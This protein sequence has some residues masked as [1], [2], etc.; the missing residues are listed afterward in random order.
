M[1]E[2]IVFQSILLLKPKI[3]FTHN[4]IEMNT[5][6]RTVSTISYFAVQLGHAIYVRKGAKYNTVG[7][8]FPITHPINRYIKG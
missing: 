3:P 8:S 7:V 4:S 6:K 1:T 2:K 5:F